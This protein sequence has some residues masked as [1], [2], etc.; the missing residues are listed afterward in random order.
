MIL[1]SAE[2]REKIKD[3]LRLKPLWLHTDHFI[4]S[5]KYFQSSCCLISKYSITFIF[6]RNSL[7]CIRATI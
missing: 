5:C 6:N 1:R 2:L 4:F 3:L 7:L